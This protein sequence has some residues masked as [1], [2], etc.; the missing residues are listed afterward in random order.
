MS[1][2]SEL[3]EYFKKPAKSTTNLKSVRKCLVCGKE[4]FVRDIHKPAYCGGTCFRLRRQAQ[5]YLNASKGRLTEG[6]QLKIKL[7]KTLR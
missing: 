7:S 3:R 2:L 1:E 5:K 6:E 4:C